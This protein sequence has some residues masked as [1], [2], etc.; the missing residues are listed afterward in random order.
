MMLESKAR[1]LTRYMKFLLRVVP[2]IE[3]PE[4]LASITDE[5][6]DVVEELSFDVYH[7]MPYDYEQ[8]RL[9][10][11]QPGNQ[12]NAFTPDRLAREGRK[13]LAKLG[14]DDPEGYAVGLNSRL[15]QY[16]EVVHLLMLDFDGGDHAV[17]ASLRKIGGILIKTER[18]FHFIGSRVIKGHRRW[19]AKL[20]QLRRGRLRRFLDIKHVDYAL[21]RGYSTIRLTSGAEK[22]H[23]PFF[24]KEV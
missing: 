21:K 14:T 5:L 20:R 22:P 10:V 2:R 19:E 4:V 17:E 1:V 24:Y 12:V 16:G 11:W 7:P 6:G 23:R 18:G 13:M 9:T 15:N 3:I 8:T